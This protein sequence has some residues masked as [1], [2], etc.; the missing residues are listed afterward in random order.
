MILKT[1]L[2]SPFHLR[3]GIQ[4]ISNGD[5]LLLTYL[6]MTHT[7]T[8]THNQIKLAVGAKYFEL[9]HFLVKN[10]VMYKHFM[11]VTFLFTKMDYFNMQNE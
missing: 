4:S 5:F 3:S 2:N 6:C 1:K 7:H 11:P 10:V 9:S 8:H